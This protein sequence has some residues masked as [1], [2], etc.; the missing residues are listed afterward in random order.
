VL[1]EL[2]CHH[3][4]DGVRVIRSGNRDDVD[5]LSEFVEQLAE[6]VEA[7][8][9]GKE[10]VL[11]IE[12]FVVDVTNADEVCILR[13]LRAVAVP[14]PADADAGEM[15]ALVGDLLASSSAQV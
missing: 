9:L 3:R 1:A 12:P 10:L 2:D 15:K 5:V 7:L 11:G 13:G 14:F 6:I 4:R 8:R